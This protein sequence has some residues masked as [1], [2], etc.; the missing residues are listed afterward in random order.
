MWVVLKCW[1]VFVM[2]CCCLMIW[3]LVLSFC[4]VICEE[5]CVRKCCLGLCNLLLS[6]MRFLISRLMRL[7]IIWIFRSWRFFGVVLN[8][9]VIKWFIMVLR[10]LRCVF[11]MFYGK[12][13]YVILRRCLNLI[14]VRFLSEFMRM[15]LECLVVVC[16][17]WW[18]VIMR[19]I[20]GWWWIICLMMFLCCF[21]WLGLLLFYFVFLL[22]WFCC[23]CLVWISLLDCR[24]LVILSVDL[25]E[26][27]LLSGECFV[28]WKM[29]GLLGWFCY[30]FWC[31]CCGVWI[32]IV[33]MILCLWRICFFVIV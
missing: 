32:L 9:C 6:L 20:C 29:F 1:W 33:W 2:N 23:W 30:G 17:E 31:E 3:L 22:F 21:S 15:S 14:R 7:F 25:W 19:F 28:I 11:L 10:M 27:N 5:W 13:W 4:L 18:L 16:L 26:L 12:R 24:V 8:F